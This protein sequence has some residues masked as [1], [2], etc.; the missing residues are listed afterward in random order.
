MGYRIFAVG[1]IHGCFRSF[2]TLIEDKIRFNSSD[3]LILLG[4]YID[5]GTESKE[6]I[7]YILRLQQNGFDIIPLL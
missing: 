7:D 5:R 6:V 1:Y 3:K 2:K 4:D